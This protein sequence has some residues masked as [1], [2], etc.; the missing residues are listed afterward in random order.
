M[1]TAMDSSTS[2]EPANE[3][4]PREV[5]L[6]TVREQV[7]AIDE[8]IG[9]AEQKLQVFDIDLSQMGW[10][11][12]ARATNLAAFL[13]RAPAARF[14]LIVHDTR[15]MQGSCPRLTNLLR[16]YSQSITVYQT[17]REARVAMDPLVIVDGRHFLHRFHID[18]PRATLVI[19]NP[20]QASPLATRFD[21]IWA[22]GEPGMAGTVLGL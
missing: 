11:T 10:E 12:L 19:G 14:D 7:A 1:D 16:Q 21:E 18:Q 20:L 17:G 4:A 8:L 15:W 6:D 5:R 3:Q 9:L 22:T 2:I 13:R